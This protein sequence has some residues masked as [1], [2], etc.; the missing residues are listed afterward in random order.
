MNY[1]KLTPNASAIPDVV[2]LLKEKIPWLLAPS[3]ASVLATTKRSL[4]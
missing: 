3:T 2:S 1:Y 4:L